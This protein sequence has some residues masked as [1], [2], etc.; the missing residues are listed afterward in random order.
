MNDPIEASGYRAPTPQGG[1]LPI[2]M[3]G[4][5][6]SRLRPMTDRRPKPLVPVDGVPVIRRILRLLYRFGYDRAVITVQYLADTLCE[7]LGEASEGVTLL[8]A[9]EAAAMGTAGS[10]R[11]AF[12]AY[13]AGYEGALILSGDAVVDCDLSAFTAFHGERGADATLLAVRREETEAFGVILSTDSGR[14]T[15]FSEKPSPAGSLS[16]LVNTGIYLLDRSLIASIPERVPVDFGR[17][18]F[19]AALGEGKGLYCLT[20]DGYWCDIGTTDAYLACNLAVAGGEIPGI[21]SETAGRV[22]YGGVVGSVVGHNCFLSPGCEIRE[23]VLWDNVHV[24]RGAR[25][26][27]AVLCEG[28]VI[29]RDVIIAPGCVLGEGVVIGDGVY[30]PEGTGIPAGETLHRRETHEAPYAIG[31]RRGGDAARLRPYLTD[32]GYALTPFPKGNTPDPGFCIALGRALSVYARKNN[33][34]CLV[35]VAEDTPASAAAFSLLYGAVACAD[36]EGCGG[37][38][39]FCEGAVPVS[40]H[41]AAG[42]WDMEGTGGIRVSLGVR[43]GRPCVRFF[44]GGGLYPAR[45]FER[46]MDGILAPLLASGGALD[47]GTD[48]EREKTAAFTPVTPA[49]IPGEVLNVAY[50]R[51]YTRPLPTPGGR[52]FAFRCG[53]G[54]ENALLARLLMACGGEQ[55]ADAPYR[56]SVHVGTEADADGSL[57]VTDMGDPGRVYGHWELF[58]LWVRAK[59]PKEICVPVGTPSYV[60][61]AA[62][63]VD[64]AVR[65]FSHDPTLEGRK[66]A[67]GRDKVTYAAIDGILLARE[68][69][70]LLC[71][72][73]KPLARLYKETFPVGPR[74][75]TVAHVRRSMLYYTNTPVTAV[76]RLLREKLG[77]IPD[78]EGI[79]RHTKGEGRVRVVATRDRNLRIIADAYSM[80]AAERLCETARASLLREKND[81]P[82]WEN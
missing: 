74:G 8:Y 48:R 50:L 65:F 27:G 7:A 10:V 46:R 53:D 32:D 51:M 37:G 59:T 16:D 73:Q 69:A 82:H 57:S 29:G 49:R 26:E 76:S 2:I 20:W 45:D 42:I 30:L 11:D 38:V 17:D 35:S 25:I 55:R 58:S 78:A 19:P 43:D 24:G 67:L 47:R 61:E 34:P 54:G 44:D 28:V 4:G 60:V 23:S 72:A 36:T 66:G 52:P 63:S 12:A 39:S 3:A 62:H 21:P 33:T 41:R 77:F 71:T 1:F 79:Y 31:R 81:A 14:I 22:T 9:R 40:V 18:I 6:G 5:Q 56:F 70:F 75:D 64:C 68:I 15:G 13:G 80:E